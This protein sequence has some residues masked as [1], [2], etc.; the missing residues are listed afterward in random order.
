MNEE[1]VLITDKAKQWELSPEFETSDGDYL[2]GE[3]GKVGILGPEFIAG[4]TG[5]WLWHFWGDEQTIEGGNFKVVA[6]Y[7]ETGT[8]E[9]ALVEHAGTANVK[10][11]WNYGKMDYGPNGIRGSDSS[12]PSNMSL[13]KPGLWRLEVSIGNK[14]VGSIVVEVKEK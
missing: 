13:S 3:E 12:R 5:K 6:I 7:K 14:N 10:K 2:I 9:K 1:D 8:K 11:V 4:E